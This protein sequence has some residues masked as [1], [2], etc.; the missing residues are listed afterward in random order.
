[1]DRKKLSALSALYLF[2]NSIFFLNRLEKRQ[3][4]DIGRDVRA[5]DIRG[6]DG[7]GVDN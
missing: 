4:D 5:V 6:R 1:M 2:T 3:R 7:R